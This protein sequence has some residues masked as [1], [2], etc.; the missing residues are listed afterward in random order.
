MYPITLVLFYNWVLNFNARN[1]FLIRLVLAF[2][3]HGVHLSNS[4]VTFC[5]V[6]IM[7]LIRVRRIRFRD[8]DRFL[9][10]L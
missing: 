8:L 6:L 7:A 5:R 9:L 10:R 1:R 2:D 3:R 4:T